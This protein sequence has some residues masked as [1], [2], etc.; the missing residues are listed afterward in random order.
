MRCTNLPPDACGGTS[1]GG[2]LH[3]YYWR[4]PAAIGHTNRESDDRS[5][6]Q[7]RDLQPCRAC[8]VSRC[9]SG[10]PHAKC[11]ACTYLPTS[12]EPL[13][14]GGLHRYYLLGADRNLT[15]AVI[16]RYSGR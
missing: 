6:G 7:C 16:D 3:C 1:L 9:L 12:V 10:A 5:G 14:P 15:I 2:P 8:G 13:L 4:V 11:G